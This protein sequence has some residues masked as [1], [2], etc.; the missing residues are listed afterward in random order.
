M[1]RKWEFPAGRV[2]VMSRKNH[3]GNFDQNTIDR[4][5]LRT[6]IQLASEM[7]KKAFVKLTQFKRGILDGDDKLE[8]QWAL[9]K[10]F[11]IDPSDG[12][13][14]H[15]L[16]GITRVYSAIASGLD[17][18]YDIV[19]FDP[20]D[21]DK[22]TSAVGYVRP[23]RTMIQAGPQTA[24]ASPI[25]MRL[26]IPEEWNHH[27]W[28]QGWTGYE[29]VG[30][31]HVSLFVL[32]P[33]EPP[34]DAVA[35]T[36]VHEASHKFARTTD[37]LYKHQSFAKAESRGEQPP[38][39]QNTLTIGGKKITPMGGAKNGVTISPLLYLENADSYAWT[40]RRLWKRL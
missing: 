33:G 26:L 16:D 32:L 23:T 11:S 6:A 13:Y 30:R 15:Y 39:F 40:A 1:S 31:I 10:Y 14:N 27:E 8:V 25:Q 7:A 9:A 4:I 5:K 2:T 29:E 12:G 35:R 24:K 3:P 22:F 18:P 19:V 28:D 17:A 20:T 34:A 21:K 38:E 36:I 37:V